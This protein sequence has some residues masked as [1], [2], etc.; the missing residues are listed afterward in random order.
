MKID[1]YRTILLQHFEKS[2][3]LPTASWRN[4]QATEVEGRLEGDEIDLEDGNR[5]TAVSSF[6]P[7]DAPPEAQID[8]NEE[9]HLEPKPALKENIGVAKATPVLELKDES[10]ES[11]IRGRGRI[12]I[13]N[14]SIGTMTNNPVQLPQ[15]EKH[16]SEDGDPKDLRLI[17]L[18]NFVVLIWTMFQNQMSIAVGHLALS[19]VLFILTRYWGTKPALTQVI[20]KRSR[21]SHIIVD[22]TILVTEEHL[23][24]KAG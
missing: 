8:D 5:T 24:G 23:R 4:D 9:R 15:D 21:F 18:K 20:G 7:Q 2:T 22:T 16:A 11:T 17:A 6:P 13:V 1:I 19:V 10:A 12:E 3:G 14:T